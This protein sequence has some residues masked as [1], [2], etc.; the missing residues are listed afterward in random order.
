M[1][2]DKL[3]HLPVKLFSTEAA[4]MQSQGKR[5]N[6]PLPWETIMTAPSLENSEHT[7]LVCLG[8]LDRI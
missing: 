6:I 7:L 3:V 4:A 5:T 2:N 8:K 1:L